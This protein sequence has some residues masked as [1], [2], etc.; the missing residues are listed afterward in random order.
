MQQQLSINI[1]RTEIMKSILCYGDSNTHGFIPENGRRFPFDVRWTGVLQQQLGTNA[2]II[3]E[4]LNGRTTVYDEPLRVGKNGATYLP[5]LIESHSP[6]DIVVLMLGIN[7]LLD[8][9]ELTAHDAASGVSRLVDTIRIC[10]GSLDYPAPTIVI[11]A[12]PIALTLPP[13]MKK[14]CPGDPAK[15]HQLAEHYQRLAEAQ[16]CLFIDAATFVETSAVDGV[17]LDA[18]NHKKLGLAIAELLTPIV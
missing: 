8:F 14:H 17:H 13:E 12:P 16:D 1:S 5:I 18:E 3:E 6:L 2:R 15:S 4:G 7:D 10:S 9:F 11:V